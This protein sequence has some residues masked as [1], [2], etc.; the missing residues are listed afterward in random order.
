MRSVIAA[1]A[2]TLLTG[3]TSTEYSKVPEATGVWVPVNPASL[4]VEAAPAPA[5][6]FIQL[7]ARPGYRTAR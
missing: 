6:Q 7:Q 5:G 1:T 3:C 2:L 4:M